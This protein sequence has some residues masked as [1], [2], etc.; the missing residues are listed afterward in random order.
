MT[1]SFAQ[2][3]CTMDRIEPPQSLRQLAGRHR[4]P[5]GMPDIVSLRM[6]GLRHDQPETT[7]H[8]VLWLNTWLIQGFQLSL[9][10]A[11]HI[12]RMLPVLKSYLQ[13]WWINNLPAKDLIE[14]FHITTDMLADAFPELTKDLLVDTFPDIAHSF[15]KEVSEWLPPPI[16]WVVEKVAKTVD[17]VTRAEMLGKLSPYELLDNFDNILNTDEIITRIGLDAGQIGAAFCTQFAGWLEDTTG[18][19]IN[20]TWFTIGEAAPNRTERAIAIG[21]MLA[22]QYDIAGLCEVWEQDRQAD[23]LK[24]AAGS[25][26]VVSGNLGP[27][28]DGEIAGSGLL[29]VT[30]DGRSQ[31]SSG[32]ALGSLFDFPGLSVFQGDPKDTRVFSNQ[33]N[34]ARDADAWSRKG[35]LL[36]VI[37][38]GVG[39]ID[40]YTTH[41]YEGGYALEDPTPEQ[42][43]SV[44]LS[45]IKDIVSFI[46]E[47]H[48]RDHVAV[49]MGDFNV[50]AH[51]PE[52]ATMIDQLGLVDLVDLWPYW[53]QLPDG[54]PPPTHHGATND[55]DLCEPMDPNLLCDPTDASLPFCAEPGSKEKPESGRRIDYIFIGQ[56]RP[57]HHFTI[58]FARVRRRGDLFEGSKLSD[59]LGLDVILIVSPVTHIPA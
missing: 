36:T 15:V 14:P 29:T 56:P 34:H 25:G 1:T 51:E 18:W 26:R 48:N 17:E 52:Y 49:L 42:A 9:C 39:T 31:E 54:E 20:F 11:I 10:N 16:G 32:D 27:L 58:D 37:N 23:L 21:K 5:D 19:P 44:K 43:W 53:N 13:G 38:V 41:L 55:T 59:H 47:T 8:R 57:E 46:K 50:A 4:W 12:G 45:Q 30:F 28:E 6:L 40:L 24:A 35:V 3:A 22:K 2:I 7:K 33:G